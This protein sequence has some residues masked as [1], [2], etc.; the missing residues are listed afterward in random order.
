MLVRLAEAL[1]GF[2]AS[3]D[4]RRGFELGT[5]DTRYAGGGAQLRFRCTD[6]KGHVAVEV[7]LRTDLRYQ[8]GQ[9]ETAEFVVPMEPAAIDDF[10]TDISRMRVGVGAVARLRQVT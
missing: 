7:R 5:F 9:P 8:G 2:P 3:S 4:D 6:A 1:R 10:V